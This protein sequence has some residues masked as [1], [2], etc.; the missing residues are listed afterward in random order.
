MEMD[1]HVS[2][3]WAT[4]RLSGTQQLWSLDPAKSPPPHL[5]HILLCVKMFF[6]LMIS[7]GTVFKMS[8][9]VQKRS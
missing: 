1:I 7:E 9:R 3:P 4:C 8:E 2:G 5:V 6:E